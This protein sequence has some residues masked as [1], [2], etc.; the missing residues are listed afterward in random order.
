MACKPYQNGAPP[1]PSDSY[2]ACSNAQAIFTE[3]KVS[4]YANR[5]G[6]QGGT[7]HWV[8]C[9]VVACLRVNRIIY[10]KATPGDCTG[11]SSG[12]YS[13]STSVKAS[14]ALAQVASTDPEPI[15]R[16]V[17]AV[18]SSIFGIFG[19]AHTAAVANEQTTLCQAAIDYNS[20]ASYAEA[21][22][23]N[24]ATPLQAALASLPQVVGQ[25]ETRI[26][27]IEQPVNAAYGVHKAL[28]ALALMNKEL[29]YP[30]LVNTPSLSVVT[31]P[32]SPPVAIPGSAAPLASLPGVSTLRNAISAIPGVSYIPGGSSTVLLLGLAIIGWKLIFGR[33]V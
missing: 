15:S 21:G 27:G 28:D 12:V 6:A 23:Q 7:G 19:Q 18:G 29:V 16:D 26:A 24:G 25:I 32:G 3:D 9:Y 13:P 14:T 4:Q 2:L 22:L 10:Y 31:T 20:F 17:L 1:S 8:Y 5:V 30:S 11:G 33:R